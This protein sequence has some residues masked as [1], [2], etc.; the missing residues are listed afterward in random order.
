MRK[1]ARP[2]AIREVSGPETRV[3]L[4]VALIVVACSLNVHVG[5]NYPISRF[6]NSEYKKELPMGM[7]RPL[8]PKFPLVTSSYFL[9]R[10]SAQNPF[11]HTTV[12][13]TITQK[14]GE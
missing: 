11:I 1:A 6:R 10:K 4:G 2:H 3:S 14:G 5:N 9:L 7:A 13:T 8:T 12:N